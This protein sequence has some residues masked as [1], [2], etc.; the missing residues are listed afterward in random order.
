MAPWHVPG[1]SPRPSATPSAHGRTL[2]FLRAGV[3]L[4]QESRHV[5]V[6]KDASTTAWGA[7]C[8]GHAAAGLW[9]G[10]SCSDISIASSY[11]QY[12][13][14]CA[15][16]KCC[17]TRSMYWSVRT[18][19][20]PLRTSTTKAVY[21]PVAC[22][23][24][25]AMESE[26]SEVA[27][28]HSGPRRAQSCSRRALTS[29]RPSGRMATPPRGT[30]A[31]LETLRGCSDRPVCLPGHV[32]L[33]AVFLP[34]RGDPQYRRTGIQLASGPMQICVP[35]VSLLAQTLCKV[36][37][38]E[39]QVLLVAP[40]W[41]NQTWFPELMLLATAPPWQNPLRRDLLYRVTERGHPLAPTSRLVEFPRMIPGSRWATSSCSK[42]YHF[43]QGPVY[44]TRLQAEVEPVRRLVFSLPGGPP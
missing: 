43:C 26:A 36:R 31:D 8:N 27:S 7:M 5:V 23:N 25:P 24:S 13:L 38:D 2:H 19:L 41:P 4:E 30:P 40:Y 9:T 14:L 21:A 15:A 12:G 10:P 3:P 37:E 11:W 39:E 18:T 1:Q 17:Y 28:R 35:P 29:A 16:S 6:S 20:R 33:P 44:K 34:V 42:K 32:P 22:R